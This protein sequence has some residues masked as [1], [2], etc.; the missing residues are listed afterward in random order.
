MLRSS[1]VILAL[2]AVTPAMAGPSCQTLEAAQVETAAQSQKLGG[3]VIT[4]SGVEAHQYLDV[5]N[6]VPPQTHLDADKV[7]LL[8][9]PER[10]AVI[11]L[12]QSSNVCIAGRIG[13]A[14][15]ERAIKAARGLSV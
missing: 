11:G 2:L 3:E 6:A 12:V 8:V 9:V 7:M 5:V 14:V 10:G 15:H 1:L 13:S 4:L